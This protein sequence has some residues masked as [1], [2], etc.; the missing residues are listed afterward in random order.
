MRPAARSSWTR[1]R[2]TRHVS[3]STARYP[4]RSHFRRTRPIAL[5]AGLLFLV[6]T[7]VVAR[8]LMFGVEMAGALLL[9]ARSSVIRRFV[10]PLALLLSLAVLVR[11]G[12]L[13]GVLFN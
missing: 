8:E 1:S 12:L 9:F 7:E 5:V 3:R 4:T 2:N 13:P 6:A 10:F 11:L